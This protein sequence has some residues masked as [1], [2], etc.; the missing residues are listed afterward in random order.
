MEH[1]SDVDSTSSS[2]ITVSVVSISVGPPS[3]KVASRPQGA[4]YVNRLIKLLVDTIQTIIST[5]EISNSVSPAP[6]SQSSRVHTVPPFA[7]VTSPLGS[8]SLQTI[9]SMNDPMSEKYM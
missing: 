6:P 5:L 3:C 1:R 8:R 7:H 4:I 9:K 2:S